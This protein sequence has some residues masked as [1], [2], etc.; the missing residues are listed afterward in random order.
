NRAPLS[1]VFGELLYAREYRG[2]QGAVELSVSAGMGRGEPFYVP[3]NLLLVGTMN[4]ADRSLAMVD[5]A[6]RRRFRFVEVEPN[7][8]VLDL[9]LAA[10]GNSPNA[11]RVVLDLFRDLNDR[12]AQSIDPEH[13]LGHTYFMLDPLTPATL[14]RLW[15]TAI[16]PLVTEYFL[17]P[18]GEVAE[19]RVLFA[20]AVAALRTE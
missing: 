11:R 1:R 12:L 4:S 9:W 13:R 17:P 8:D 7:P 15:R 5:Y 19:Y 10:R 18:G 14:D 16:K 2:P 6:L 3:E 20:E